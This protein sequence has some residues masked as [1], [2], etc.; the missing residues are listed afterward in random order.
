MNTF[1]TLLCAYEIG[2][3][4]TQKEW[5]EFVEKEGEKMPIPASANL[6]ASGSSPSTA[7]SG[8][9]GNTQGNITFNFGKDKSY[10]V[11]LGIAL[12]IG[13]IYFATRKRG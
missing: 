2:D 3:S 9:T 7:I 4:Q 5:K 13:F 6:P 12:G 11:A 8:V 1:H 10:I